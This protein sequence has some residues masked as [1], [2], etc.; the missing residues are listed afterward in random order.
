MHEAIK[1]YVTEPFALSEKLALKTPNV[2]IK[3][4]VF[5]LFCAIFRNDRQSVTVRYSALKVSDKFA[6]PTVLGIFFYY[7]GDFCF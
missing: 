5:R 2:L 7:S 4:C 6:L 3:N 1:F